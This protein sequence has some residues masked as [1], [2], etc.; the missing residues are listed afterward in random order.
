[1]DAFTSLKT[2]AL[3]LISSAF[4]SHSAHAGYFGAAHSFNS[5]ATFDEQD[6]GFRVDFGSNATPWLDLEWSYIDYGESRY[7]DP[8]FTEG[9]ID[10]NDD[11]GSFENIGYGE[12]SVNEKVARFD[13]LASVRT[14]GISAGLKFKKSVNDWMQVYAR[15]S[16]M[17]WQAESISMT[18]F[19]Q[20]P[21]FDSDGNEL[22]ENSTETPNNLN[23]CNTTTYCRIEDTDNPKS[24]WA[25]DFWYGYGAIFKPFSWLAIRTEYSILTLNAEAFPRGKLESFSTGLEIHF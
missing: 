16:F 8:S 7:N 14:Q 6:D 24:T 18:I 22:P 15:A 17:A 1:M 23:D 20:R 2:C 5:S 21:A 13:G 11:N 19:A 10:D 12:Q 3:V 4:I 9:D 25:V